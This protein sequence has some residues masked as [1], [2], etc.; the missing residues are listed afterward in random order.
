MI[1]AKESLIGNINASD[2]L[3]GSL[4]KAIEYVSPTTQEKSITPTKEVQE[5][6]P[7]KGIFALSKVIVEAIPDEYK[8]VAGTIDINANGTYDVANYESANVNVSGDVELEESYRSLLDSTL[9]ANTTKLPSDLTLIGNYAFYEKT[10]LALT[11]LSDTITA[12]G[13]YAFN[14][15]TNLAINKL[16]SKLNSIGQRAFYN[17]RK[18]KFNKIPDNVPLIDNSTFYM[19][20]GLERVIMSNSLTAIGEGAFRKCTGL[21]YVECFDKLTSIGNRSF[22]DTAIETFIIRRTT[23][24]SLNTTSFLN[25]PIAGGTGYIY[26]PD[27]AINTYKSATNWSAYAEQIKGV[28]ELV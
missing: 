7:D 14:Y 12:I 20:Y 10:N 28:S 11:E 9:G 4:N 19:C 18:I 3:Q 21:I 13:D 8:E 26:V 22:Q 16:P 5:V 17:C 25:T 24:P 1:E 15:C 23:P 27:E 2:S 6:K